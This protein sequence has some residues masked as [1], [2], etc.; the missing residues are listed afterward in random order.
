MCLKAGNKKHYKQ[1]CTKCVQ[2]SDATY[3]IYER[4]WTIKN[5]PSHKTF[6]Q[7]ISQ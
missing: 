5:T 1:V 7:D 2:K 3:L 4:A 6:K